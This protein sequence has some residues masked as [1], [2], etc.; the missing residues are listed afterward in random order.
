MS[1][2]TI[3]NEPSRL[4]S[5]VIYQRDSQPSE[6]APEFKPGNTPHTQLGNETLNA[7]IPWQE[8]VQQIQAH[9]TQEQL[10]E[11]TGVTTENLLNILNQDY[12]KLNFRTGARILGVHC[13]FFP[14]QY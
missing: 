7:N 11:E 9:Y 4:S 8:I 6:N 2:E 10:I 1:D 13:R 12:S 3:L 5:E 14:E